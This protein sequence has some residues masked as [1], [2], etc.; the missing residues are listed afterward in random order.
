MKLFLLIGEFHIVQEM[1]FLP[2]H[3]HPPD[4][5]GYVARRV[6]APSMALRALGTNPSLRALLLAVM[7]VTIWAALRA[8]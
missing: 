1:E 2:A 6:A 5:G 7:L 3:R 8:H 4:R